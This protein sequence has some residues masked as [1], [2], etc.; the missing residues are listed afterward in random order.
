MEFMTTDYSKNKKVSYE[1]L[2]EQEYEAIVT[3]ASEHATPSGAESFQLRLTIRNDL[4][5]VPALAES[6]AKFHNRVVFAENWKRKDTKQYNIEG[7]QYI[8]DAV[9]VPEGTV[10]NSV[11]DFI[12]A[13][14]GK[15]VRV[16]I[17]Q[18]TSNYKGEDTTRNVVSPWGFKETEF[19]QVNH[20]FKTKNGTPKAADPFASSGTPVEIDDKDLPF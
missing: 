20:T 17:K 15:P 10:L 18:E 13:I 11:E 8:L 9:H 1:P 14:T 7:L 16:Y 5:N 19:P 4:D 3:Q 2:P 6:N 12:K